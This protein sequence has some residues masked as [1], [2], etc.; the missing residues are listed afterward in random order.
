MHWRGPTGE[1]WN[2]SLHIEQRAMLTSASGTGSRNTWVGMMEKA[3]SFQRNQKAAEPRSFVASKLKSN[4][5]SRAASYQ[6]S[7]SGGTKKLRSLVAAEPRSCVASK[8]GSN[9][10]I[11]LPDSSVGIP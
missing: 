6:L 8:L 2:C 7:A 3:T 10:G 5:N 4:N 9:R 1:E 11:K